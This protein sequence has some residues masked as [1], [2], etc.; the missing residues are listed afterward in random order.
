MVFSC[1]RPRSLLAL[2]VLAIGMLSC[3]TVPEEPGED[4]TDPVPTSEPTDRTPT[5]SAPAQPAD[6]R[7]L[8]RELGLPQI[9]S[10]YALVVRD[11]NDDGWE[12][13][14]ISHHGFGADLYINDN[15]GTTS[16]GLTHVHEF[17]DAIHE[18]RDRHGCAIGDVDLDGL[19]DIFCAKG[20]QSGSAKKW[21]ELW[22]QGPEGTWT[23][24]AAAYGVEDIWGRGRF[25]VFLDLN[26]DPYPDL[27]VGNDAPRQ[28]DHPTPNRTYVNEE[29]ARFR[30]VRLGVSRELGDTCTE[31]ADFDGN[32]W[33]DL[34][35][36]GRSQLYL[37]SQRPAGFD[38]VTRAVGMPV[39]R[40]T[41]AEFAHFDG[42]RLLDLVTITQERLE[43]RLQRDDRTFG[44]VVAGQP[45]LS[46]HGLAVGDPDGDGDTDIFVVEGCLD[47]VNRDDL[48]LENDADGAHF[49]LHTVQ[50]VSGGCGDT[51]AALDID[52]DG[53]DEFIVLN[54]GGKDQPLD[55]DG[56]DQVLTLGDW[57]P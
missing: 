16:Q 30:E 54:G 56:P 44:P 49:T 6:F 47:R 7:D 18:R 52:H 27:F 42:D 51:A 21:N 46:G 22:M 39:V 3:S 10:T 1:R 43:V 19:D 13:L 5:E 8:G 37:F 57:R 35:I 48:F 11:V 31:R 26:R 9:M 12:D 32:G 36:C 4:S 38:D 20:A 25:P 41:A 53:M 34:L 2:V 17:V 29:G 15:D 24:E 23:D 55:L 28:D 45:L 14:L 40:A 33:A 50:P